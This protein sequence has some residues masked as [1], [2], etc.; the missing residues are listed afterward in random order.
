MFLLHFSVGYKM[1][2][3]STSFAKEKQHFCCSIQIPLVTSQLHRVN[4]YIYYIL[5]STFQRERSR[6]KLLKYKNIRQ[7]LLLN[8][9]CLSELL[10]YLA[11]KESCTKC[12]FVRLFLNFQNQVKVS[13]NVF[14]VHQPEQIF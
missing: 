9:E 1:F 13:H 5:T 12:N 3:L 6:V 11:G 14:L 4:L 7:V 10:F 2:N 8:Y